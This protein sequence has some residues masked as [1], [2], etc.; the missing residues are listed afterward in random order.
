MLG[1]LLALWVAFLKA[2][3]ELVSKVFTDEKKKGSIN[4]Y[5]LIFWARLFSVLLLLPLAVFVNMETPS[6]NIIYLMIISSVLNAVANVTAIKAVKHGDLWLVWPLSSLTIPFLLISSYF[7]AGEIINIYWFIWVL[8]IFTWTYFLQISE[9]KWDIFG[10]LKAIYHNT[11]AR[12]MLFTA[13]VWSISSPIDKLWVVELWAFAWMFYTNILV[14]ICIG[15]YMIIIRRSFPVG[16][17]FKK[18]NAVKMLAITGL[19]GVWV[20]LQLLAL[21]FTLV[22]Y[23]IALKRASWMFS[24]ILWYIFY[25]E[26]NIWE[27]LIA[28]LIML[29]WVWVISIFGN[30]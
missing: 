17:I 12:Y 26:K 3:W 4:E 27:K 13:V 24:V 10:P 15:L 21:K 5:V 9:L 22:V 30:I 6:W 20:F 23:V 16:E 18:N 2:L 29:A 7:I 8:I 25:K 11:W 19:G 28:T 14:S 1:I